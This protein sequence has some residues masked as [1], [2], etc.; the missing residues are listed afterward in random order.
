MERDKMLKPDPK[1]ATIEVIDTRKPYVAPQLFVLKAD[2][3]ESNFA[4]AFESS[5]GPGPMFQAS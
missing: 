2:N 4:G 1:T 3:T 5:F